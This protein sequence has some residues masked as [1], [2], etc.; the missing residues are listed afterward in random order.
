MQ[1][2][3]KSSDFKAIWSVVSSGG[4]QAVSRGVFG[5][6]VAFLNEIEHRRQQESR[7]CG[8][9][10]KQKRDMQKDPAGM[11]LRERRDLL[12][13]NDSRNQAQ[14]EADGQHEDTERDRSITP[15]DDKKCRCQAEARAATG[16]R[17]YRPEDGG[18]RRSASQ[19]TR[20][21]GR[22]APA[23]AAGMAT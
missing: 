1:G 9:G 4:S 20:Q 15:V 2:R 5:F 6:E 11:K 19:P 17:E 23:M 12:P 10:R 14:Q 18:G 3:P 8:I 21:S 16:S 7:Q 13:R 22:A